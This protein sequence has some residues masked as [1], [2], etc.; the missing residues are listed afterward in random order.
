MCAS[1]CPHLRFCQ[2]D[3]HYFLCNSD[4]SVILLNLHDDDDDDDDDD[5]ARYK[6][7]I[8]L[9][10]IVYFSSTPQPHNSLLELLQV[11]QAP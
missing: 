11:K 3:G 2:F 7:Y 5:C 4:L 9:Y 8:V 1:D 6:F 10:Y